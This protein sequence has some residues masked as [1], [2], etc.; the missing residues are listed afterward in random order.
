MRDIFRGDLINVEKAL[1]CIAYKKHFSDEFVEK[2]IKKY[3]NKKLYTYRCYISDKNSLVLE[4][5]DFRYYLKDD[6]FNEILKDK[7]TSIRKPDY[8]NN[9]QY[10]KDMKCYY[11]RLVSNINY[12][13]YII[14]DENL[15]QNIYI[16][17][18]KII[19]K[20]PNEVYFING[21]KIRRINLKKSQNNN[22]QWINYVLF[23]PID[24]WHNNL[25]NYNSLTRN[26]YSEIFMDKILDKLDLTKDTLPY[27]NENFYNNN[28]IDLSDEQINLYQNEIS[29]F[30]PLVKYTKE[31]FKIVGNE[32]NCFSQENEIPSYIKKKIATN[33]VQ[34]KLQIKDIEFIVSYSNPKFNYVNNQEI[35]CRYGVCK[36]IGLK[37]IN[38]IKQFLDLDISKSEL[39]YSGNSLKLYYNY[40][41][42]Y[43]K[44]K[45]KNI[46]V[47][48]LN[49]L[50]ELTDTNHCTLFDSLR[51]FQ[52]AIL[53]RRRYKDKPFKHLDMDYL[54]KNGLRDIHDTLSQ[55]SRD[56]TNILNYKVFDDVSNYEKYEFTINGYQFLMPRN[57]SELIR[58]ADIMKNCVASYQLNILYKTSIIVY[59]TDNAEIIDY[60]R[61]NIGDIKD[62][63]SRLE[64]DDIQSPACIELREQ[65]VLEYKSDESSNSSAE[66]LNVTQCFGRHNHSLQKVNPNLYT[67]CEKYFNNL[68][69][70]FRGDSSWF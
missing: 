37:D 58:L 32:I 50:K 28:L 21:K 54:L 43:Y 67:T 3:K 26:I 25:T 52:R 6:A 36:Y 31:P 53:V 2:F 15:I 48:L 65:H 39:Q 44:G 42:K 22:Q 61:N 17:T 47:L 68:N 59:A 13:K 46:E 14:A 38:I 55:I 40:L 9:R 49:R 45:L 1:H 41:K 27:K 51:M 66:E 4:K 30:F 62:L 12:D 23:E 20:G 35:L 19:V 34:P 33:Y 29:K 8:Q 11:N 16:R 57:S 64:K 56:D 7:K 60:I 63:T 18:Q 10:F 24:H 70:N 5:N 69:A